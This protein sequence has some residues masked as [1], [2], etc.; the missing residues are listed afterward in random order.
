MCKAVGYDG[1]CA[2]HV[3]NAHP[4]LSVLLSLLF[5]M[6]VQQGIVPTAFDKEIVI[7]LVKNIDGNRTDSS[8]Y[9][10]ITL[11]PVISKLFELVLMDQVQDK[12]T[13]SNLQFGFKKKSSCSH[14]ILALQVGIEHICNSGGTATICALD[15][16]KAFDRVNFYGLF[17][18]L[19]DKS[20]PKCF[21]RVLLDWF[22]KSVSYVRWNGF[23]SLPYSIS[24]GVRQG[25][26]CPLLYL[27]CT[28]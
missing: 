9:R 20:F 5:R 26:C 14:A 13:L 25:V 4:L 19:I 6:I 22:T 21:I 15:I 11:S 10:G 27:L 7:P 2:E 18:N 3:I 8:N 16:S 28:R 1:L 23:L 12:L 17:K 24:A